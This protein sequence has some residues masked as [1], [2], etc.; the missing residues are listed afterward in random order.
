MGLL[1]GTLGI[2]KRGLG[3][4]RRLLGGEL[5]QRLRGR[6]LDEDLVDEIH[7]HLLRS[8]VGLKTAG[9]II[10]ALGRSV[11]SGAMHKG[12]AFQSNT[13]LYVCR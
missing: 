2:F 12:E 11:A 1:R 7:D 10:E 13:A 4:T 8:D 9:E 5:V 3:H 6:V